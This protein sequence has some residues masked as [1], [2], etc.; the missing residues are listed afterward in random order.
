MFFGIEGPSSSDAVCDVE[1]MVVGN[2]L[3]VIAS[4]HNEGVSLS[5]LYYQLWYEGAINIP[6]YAPGWTTW[7]ESIQKLNYQF[8]FQLLILLNKQNK[9]NKYFK[10]YFNGIKI[11]HYNF[12]KPERT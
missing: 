2:V 6:R 11:N 9:F 1:R 7:S 4:F 3:S 5:S 10:F 8:Y 12:K